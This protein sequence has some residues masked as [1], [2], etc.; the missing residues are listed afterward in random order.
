VRISPTYV[1]DL[2]NVCLDLLIDGESGLWHLANV[3]DVSW[4]ELAAR[5]AA[6]AGLSTAT[7]QPCTSAVLGEVA[8]RPRN[9]VL[10]SERATLM[11]SLDDALQRFIDDRVVARR[12]AREGRRERRG[13]FRRERA[14]G[15]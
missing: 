7:L 2:V 6:L 10:A 5:A 9:G 11:P 1:P 13:R 4:A 15:A 3:G 8:A 14:A 12:G